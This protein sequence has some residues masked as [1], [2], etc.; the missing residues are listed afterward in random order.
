MLTLEQVQTVTP[1][2]LS[3]L[4]VNDSAFGGTVTLLLQ[5]V[6]QVIPKSL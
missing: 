1:D 2:M 5:Q 3:E 4:E 6:E